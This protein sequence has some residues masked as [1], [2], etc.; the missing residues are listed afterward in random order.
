[1][2]VLLLGGSTGQRGGVEA[3]C[4]RAQ[5][6]LALYGPHE[7][8]H[9]NAD[10]AFLSIGKLPGLV[11]GM[12]KLARQ[13]SE[14][15]CLWL[16]YSNLPD[17][18][19]L[20]WAKLLGF[21][22]VVTP[23][24]GAN[25]KSQS[26]PRLRTLSNRL[27]RLADRIALL[28]PTQKNELALPDNV[29]QT[30]LR[31]F[32]AGNALA[33]KAPSEPAPANVLRLTHVSRLSEGKGTFHFVDVCRLLKQRDI[34]FTATIVGSADNATLQRLTD[35]IAAA[36][37]SDQIALLGSLNEE[38][39]TDV[40]RN[41]D[42]VVHLSTVDSFPL[43]VLEAIACAAFPI[44]IDLAGATSMINTYAGHLVPQQNCAALTAEYLATK[45]LA[46]LRREAETAGE[47]VRADYGW[48]ACVSALDRTLQDTVETPAAERAA[49]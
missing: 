19:Y 36:G 43:I 47:R 6:A 34:N 42:A 7:V 26:N 14:T 37:L 27:L 3:F 10:T 11:K 46:E 4:N 1:M 15:D 18:F 32:L 23:H 45:P 38:Q 17:L 5:K 44:C 41:S 24:L 8:H 39:Y 35:A 40:L 22:T 9:Q 28:S 31:T 30:S 49:A 2:K 21:R 12:A 20:P 29:P 13:R 48:A 16:Q 25:W 33:A